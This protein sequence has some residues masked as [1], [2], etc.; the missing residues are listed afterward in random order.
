MGWEASITEGEWIHLL[1]TCHVPGL[2]EHALPVPLRTARDRSGNDIV[3]SQSSV[4]L[5][6]SAP[7]GPKTTSELNFF[8]A[9]LLCLQPCC[10]GAHTV[11]ATCCPVR[12]IHPFDGGTGQRHSR[13]WAQRPRPWC[14]SASLA[15]VDMAPYT[16]TGSGLASE[17]L[18]TKALGSSS[19]WKVA[20]WW[21]FRWAVIVQHRSDSLEILK[22]E[23]PNNK[24]KGRK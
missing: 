4:S 19:F 20:C 14:R 8:D 22:E 17:P 23:I 18:A 2:D 16:L 15:P 12:S 11:P 10:G 9:H 3:L 24:H 7:R 1:R 13:A 5:G 21:G 6:L